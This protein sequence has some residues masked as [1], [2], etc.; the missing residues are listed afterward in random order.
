MDDITRAVNK[1]SGAIVRAANVPV[2]NAPQHRKPW[3]VV[4]AVVTGPPKTV[5]IKIMGA[6]ATTAGIRYSAAYLTPTIGDVVFCSWYGSDLIV[7]NKLA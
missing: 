7:E 5:T 2:P 3:A 1:L 4:T 6:T